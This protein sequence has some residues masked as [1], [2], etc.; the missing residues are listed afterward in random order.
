MLYVS[1]LFPGHNLK[2]FRQFLD[3]RNKNM[4][5]GGGEGGPKIE[6]KPKPKKIPI[7]G[8]FGT[9]SKTI[10]AYKTWYPEKYSVF[11][12]HTQTYSIEL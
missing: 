10:H 7:L 1:L 11:P 3:P 12:F 6:L 9:T 5:R 8:Q 4:M 2:A